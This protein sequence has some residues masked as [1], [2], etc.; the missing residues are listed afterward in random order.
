PWSFGV[1][2]DE[3]GVRRGGGIMKRSPLEGLTG[4]TRAQ[5]TGI[6]A[7]ALL[8]HVISFLMMTDSGEHLDDLGPGPWVMVV[9]AALSVAGAA[10]GPRVSQMRRS[11]DQMTRRARR[12]RRHGNDRRAGLRWA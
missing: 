5:L 8:Y 9:G 2:R 12:A 11:P 10:I 1:F 7:A 6:A 4:P 3:R